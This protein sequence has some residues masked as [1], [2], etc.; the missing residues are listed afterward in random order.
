MSDDN[1]GKLIR[2][3]NK[4]SNKVTVGGPGA[5]TMLPLNEQNR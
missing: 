5:P 4:L 3:P 2:P 1:V